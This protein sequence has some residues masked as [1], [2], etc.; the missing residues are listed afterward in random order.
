MARWATAGQGG[1][2]GHG[3]AG[4]PVFA[5]TGTAAAATGLRAGRTYTV[6][7]YTVD[8]YGNVSAPVASTVAF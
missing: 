4:Q 5:G 6:V 2:L 7:A 1:P 3:R 8:D